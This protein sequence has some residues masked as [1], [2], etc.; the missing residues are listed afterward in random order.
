ME[1]SF[2]SMGCCP[3]CG[4]EN[5]TILMDTRIRNG[6]MVESLDRHTIDPANP[7][8]G[9]REKYLKEGT[10]VICPQNGD[11]VV[12]KNSAFVRIFGKPVPNDHIAFCS[13]DVIRQLNA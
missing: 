3:I 9:C 10:M 5:G 6:K 8:D 12:L 13:E 1:K 7:C 11:S 4:K 2:V